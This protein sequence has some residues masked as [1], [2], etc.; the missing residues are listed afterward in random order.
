MNG[1]TLVSTVALTLASAAVAASAL[2]AT[3]SAVASPE[4]PSQAVAQVGSARTEATKSGWRY[5]DSYF[6]AWDCTKVGNWH[7]DRG[8][9]SAYK[10]VGSWFEDYKLYYRP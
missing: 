5:Y 6:W 9:W 2:T 1:R 10:C 7:V 4:S 3:A 8:I